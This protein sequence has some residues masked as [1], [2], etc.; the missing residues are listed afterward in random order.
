MKTEQ[1]SPPRTAPSQQ[2]PDKIQAAASADRRDARD[3]AGFATGTEDDR[4]DAFVSYSRRDKTAV[5]GIARELE[6]AGYR[7]WIDLEDIQPSAEWA[8]A[9]EENIVGSNAVLFFISPDSV[10]SSEVRRE[11]DLA[12]GFGKRIV[13]V[14]LRDTDPPD[15][16][17][18]AGRVQ[19]IDGRAGV[20]VVGIGTALDTDL[21]WVERHTYLLRKARDWDAA[22]REAGLLLRSGDLKRAEESLRYGSGKDPHLSR[23]QLD[24]VT[25]SQA[26]AKRSQ[27]T[28]LAIASGTALALGLLSAFAF[29]QS[30][31]RER[32]RQIAVAKELGTRAVLAREQRGKGLVVSAL[33]AVESLR[34][35]VEHASPSIEAGEAL[36]T[37]LSQMPRRLLWLASATDPKDVDLSLAGDRLAAVFGRGPVRIWS[38]ESEVPI[39][40][41]PAD[42]EE[43]REGIRLDPTGRHALIRFEAKSARRVVQWQ[44]W[45]TERDVVMPVGPPPDRDFEL[46]AIAAGGQVLAIASRERVLVYRLASLDLPRELEPSGQVVA[47]RFAEDG[48]AL[49]VDGFRESGRG[50]AKERLT[51]FR[52]KWS[53]ANLPSPGEA[54]PA[55]PE[56][57]WT[58]SFGSSM[59][60]F[61]LSL[62]GRHLVTTSERIRSG[63]LRSGTLTV[64]RQIESPRRSNSGE[65]LRRFVPIT[66]IQSSRGISDLRFSRDGEHFGTASTDYTAR[67]WDASSGRQVSR[68]DH[69]R[70][71]GAVAL[72]ARGRRFVSAGQDGWTG[73]WQSTASRLDR[74]GQGMTGVVTR[75]VA[76]SPDRRVLAVQAT[77]RVELWDLLS[78]QLLGRTGRAF[79]PRPR[80]RPDPV[81]HPHPKAPV[82]SSDGSTVTVTSL[83][84][85][86]TL[87]HRGE[88]VARVEHERGRVAA[89]DPTGRLGATSDGE[90]TVVHDLVRAKTAASWDEASRRLAFD[91]SGRYLAGG[92]EKTAFVW[93][94]QDGT[95]RSL[96]VEGARALAFGRQRP[97]LAV[98]S[99][100]AVH[101]FELPALTL[102]DRLP[103]AVT[104]HSLGW[105]P[106]DELLAWSDGG[107]VVVLELASRTVILDELVDRVQAL[108]F[109]PDGDMLA[110]YGLNQPTRVWSG[111]ASGEPV[112]T[113]RVSEDESVWTLLFSP[114]GRTLASGSSADLVRLT[115]VTTEALLEA[116]Y[117]RLPRNLSEQEWAELMGPEPYRCTVET[118]PPCGAATAVGE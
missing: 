84:A 83:D 67:L 116:A 31:Q 87:D 105:S 94:G 53:L 62:D 70:P 34:R 49:L 46:G 6:A 92:G 108:T 39:H 100:D 107:R 77:D 102:E 118:L 72:D 93:D 63:N 85:F 16:P 20:D 19:W 37:S 45:D 98:A 36:V 40:E 117:D 28:R 59:G 73:L 48:A 75:A 91:P 68:V 30:A 79:F 52:E 4:F 44:L 61:R 103:I 97:L 109:S 88:V 23:L 12:A 110:V 27:R 43:S 42:P 82:F 112:E 17:P 74:R 10:R 11:L 86:L 54:R 47:L 60:D 90:A 14:L 35:L 78:G 7:L 41:L 95:R 32:Q 2:P 1:P 114:D 22:K 111:L 33:L 57:V 18:P 69:G 26:R 89:L 104:A 96:P 50:A 76:F 113:L 24:F 3:G 66:T 106:G 38:S 13:T 9:I 25:A 8:S 99:A 65:E 51:L 58:A 56:A 55:A 64:W 101:L 29:W 81:F 15:L 5:Y 115:P 80:G 71:V 21:R